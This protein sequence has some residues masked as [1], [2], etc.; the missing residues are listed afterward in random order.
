V[1]AA[2]LL[3]WHHRAVR[4]PRADRVAAAL[5]EVAGGRASS[6]LDVGCGD[7]RVGR[8]VAQRLGATTLRG[9]DLLV[10]PGDVLAGAA[11]REGEPLPFAD[12]SFEVVLLADVL[13]HAEDPR[14]L[15]AESLRVASRVVAIKEHV[16]SGWASRALLLAMDMVGNAQRGVAVTGRYFGPDALREL[17][18]SAGGVITAVRWPVHVHRPGLR[19]L[20]PSELQVAAA[21]ERR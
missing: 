17:A 21:V 11:I 12:R 2:P 15:L 19:R 5:A 18:V 1:I 6:V 8:A 10:N 13:H 9:V 7:G 3:A 16:A 14:R 20:A 4:V